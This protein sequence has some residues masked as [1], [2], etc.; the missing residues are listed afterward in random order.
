MTKSKLRYTTCVLI[1]TQGLMANTALSQLEIIKSTHD[2]FWS[3][4]L[5]LEI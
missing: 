4:I 1:I 5:D 3:R 2:A